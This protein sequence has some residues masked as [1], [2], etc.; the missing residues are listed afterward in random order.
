[1]A[2][3]SP[4]PRSDRSW[5]ESDLPCAILVDEEPVQRPAN[6]AGWAWMIPAFIP[7]FAWMTWFYVGAKTRYLPYYIC[8]A[9]YLLPFIVLLV[10]VA[11]QTKS[12]QDL[13]DWLTAI[14]SVVWIGG[15]I[16]FFLVK[17]AMSLRLHFAAATGQGGANLW[18]PP[19]RIWSYIPGIHFATWI[20]AAIRS[21]YVPYYF[22][23]AIYAVPV[24]LYGV[25]SERTPDGHTDGPVWAM[26]LVLVSWI[27]CIIHAT[28]LTSDVNAH[29]E[30]AASGNNVDLE[31]EERIRQEY[32]AKPA[33]PATMPA[34]R[35]IADPFAVTTGPTTN[36]LPTT[37]PTGK[38]GILWSLVPTKEKVVNALKAKLERQAMDWMWE[39]AKWAG[40]FSLSLV[41]VWVKNKIG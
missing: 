37:A 18:P 8:G 32:E 24:C 7:W 20:H 9:L 14:G 1:M 17:K 39:G 40:G 10:I 21:K 19:W 13:P 29:I 3:I 35:A 26:T 41:I 38:A 11:P 6:S 4:P 5:K 22:L 30:K 23:A 31:L 16:H 27:V 15:L 33:A 2:H 12:N 34:P 36:T 25:L 28:I